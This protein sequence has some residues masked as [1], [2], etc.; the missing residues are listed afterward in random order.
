VKPKFRVEYVVVSV[1][2]ETYPA[3]DLGE[4][5]DILQTK[6]QKARHCTQQA[7]QEARS[8]PDRHKYLHRD[9]SLGGEEERGEELLEAKI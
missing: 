9:Q 2:F 4:N 1:V 8:S 3:K 6:W 5:A 7:K